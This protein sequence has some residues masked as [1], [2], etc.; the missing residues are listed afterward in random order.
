MNNLTTFALTN[1]C[2][3]GQIN[4]AMK[5]QN[6]QSSETVLSLREKAL[7]LVGQTESEELLAEVIAI[8]SGVPLPGAYSHEQMEASLIEAENDFQ[9]GQYVSHTSICERYGI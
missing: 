7:S 3:K 4:K 8:L 2:N 9:N 6:P 1:I 5:Q